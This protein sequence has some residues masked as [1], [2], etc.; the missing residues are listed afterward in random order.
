M[1]MPMRDMEPA[2][3]QAKHMHRDT[4]LPPPPARRVSIEEVEDTEER[5]CH[6]VGGEDEISDSADWANLEGLTK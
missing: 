1:T 6:N 2:S 3:K 5:F 4:A